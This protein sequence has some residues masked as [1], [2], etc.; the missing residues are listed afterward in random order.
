ME[1]LSWE[2]DSRSATIEIPH[3]FGD[4]NMHYRVH[5]TPST[6]SYPEPAESSTH[7][8]NHL[9]YF[10]IIFKCSLGLPN[11]PLRVS[12]FTG[13]TFLQTLYEVKWVNP[14][15]IDADPAPGDNTPHLQRSGGIHRPLHNTDPKNER[16]H[17]PDTL[18]TKLIQTRCYHPRK[19]G[20]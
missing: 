5:K 12:G 16:Q 13:A 10:N 4:P 17:A 3:P 7:S 15:K 1:D 9:K 20:K 18:A 14:C 19:Q 2:C 6:G 11:G 8:H